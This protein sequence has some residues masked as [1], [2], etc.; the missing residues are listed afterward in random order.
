MERKVSSKRVI[1]NDIAA[2][3][4]PE[5]HRLRTDGGPYCTDYGTL[6]RVQFS[7]HGYFFCNPCELYD[8]EPPSMNRWLARNS[9]TFRCRA[10]HT[11]WACP[12]TLDPDCR[13]MQPPAHSTDDDDSDS[14][15]DSLNSEDDSGIVI[16]A[17][18]V[19]KLQSWSATATGSSCYSCELARLE[20][21][22]LKGII[23]QL[24]RDNNH[25]AA[26]IE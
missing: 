26:T 17:E 19:A 7:G 23:Q 2:A 25:S 3:I 5:P 11:G 8:A 14:D 9:D 16:A 4:L 10:N 24:H 21:K 12:T 18:S 13:T 22:R 20:I 6:R 15:G 1:D